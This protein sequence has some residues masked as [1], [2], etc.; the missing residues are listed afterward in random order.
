MK[1]DL[2][3]E[4]TRNKYSLGLLEENEGISEQDVLKGKIMINES[5]MN[6]R[7]LLVEGGVMDSVKVILQESYTNFLLEESAKGAAYDK[8]FKAELSKCGYKDVASIPADKKDEFFSKVDSGWNTK[9]EPGKDG[10]K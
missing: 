4:N 3:L 7:K 2:V 9:S 8:Y 1:L 10:E 6:I 5:T